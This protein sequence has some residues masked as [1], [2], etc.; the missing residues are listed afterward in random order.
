MPGAIIAGTFFESAPT[1]TLVTVGLVSSG[2][3]WM[4]VCLRLTRRRKERRTR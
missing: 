1:S 3:F 2:L 4:W